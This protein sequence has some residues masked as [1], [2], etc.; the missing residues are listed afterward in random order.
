MN[1]AIAIMA[2]QLLRR[3]VA[4]TIVRDAATA[5]RSIMAASQP[6]SPAPP[7]TRRKRSTWLSNREQEQLKAADEE[8]LRHG[9][10][11]CGF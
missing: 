9:P 6:S 5:T 2:E 3:G 7:K 1:D 11:G 10:V 4:T 8:R